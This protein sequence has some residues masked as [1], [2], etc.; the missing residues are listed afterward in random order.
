M[1]KT[2]LA[3][4]AV[5]M[6]ILLASG[7]FAFN[8]VSAK[9]IFSASSESAV[10]KVK[11]NDAIVVQKSGVKPVIQKAGELDKKTADEITGLFE[12]EERPFR[13]EPSI[14]GETKSLFAS[15]NSRGNFEIVSNGE[16]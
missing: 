3:V 6:M 5:G 10:Q 4:L 7:A 9:T 14:V 12:N 8:I 1:K 16:F 11:L 2:I 13:E 15:E